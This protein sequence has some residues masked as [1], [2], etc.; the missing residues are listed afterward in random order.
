MEFHA[1][2]ELP[3]R[4]KLDMEDVNRGGDYLGT[5]GL[6]NRYEMTRFLKSRH[7]G[8]NNASRP[9][10]GTM[11]THWRGGQEAPQVFQGASHIANYGSEGG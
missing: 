1:N 5:R 3:I 2:T 9:P 11:Q 4:G 8:T 10:D 6:H 7:E